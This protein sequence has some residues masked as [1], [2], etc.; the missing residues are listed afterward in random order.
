MRIAIVAPSPNP[1]VFGGAENLLWGLL[2]HL[3]DHTDHVPELIKLPVRETSLVDLV[4]G[5]EAFSRLDLATFDAVITTKYPAW[6]IAHANH[7]VY[8]LHRCRG[9]YDWYPA[10]ELG[11]TEYAGRDPAAR[12]LLE[13][14]ARRR[15]QRAALPEFFERFRQLAA[16]SSAA[17]LAPHPSPLGRA[18]IRFLDGIG[19]AATSVRRYAAIAD[20]VRRRPDYFPRGAKVEVAFPPT[21]KTGFHDAGEEYFLTA[22]RFY[23]SKR[24]DLLIDAYR[25]TAIPLAFKI[26][27]TGGEEARLR[28]RAAGDSRIEFPGFV[29]DAELVELYSRAM[30]VPFAPQDEDFGYIALEAMLAGKPVITT[31]DSGGPMELVRDGVT[32]VVAA[33]DAACLARAFEQVYVER[34]WARGLGRNG[35]EV[36]QAVGWPRVMEALL[37]AVSQ[38][39]AAPRPPRPRVTVL[40]AYAVHPTDNGGRYRLHWLYKTLARHVDVDIVSLGLRTEGSDVIHPAEG[41]RELRVARTA[42]HEAADDAAKTESNAP[43]Y[44]ITALQNIHLTPD[45]ITVLRNSLA[46]SRLA[47]LAHPYMATALARAGYEGAFIHESQNCE[48]ALKTRMLPRNEVSDRLL[49]QVEMAEA[50]CVRDAR[51]VY[52]CCEADAEGLLRQYGGR[53]A[54]MIVVPN[55]TDT[56]A[57]AYADAVERIRV[58]RRVG[59]AQQ[60]VALFL[61]SGHRPNL[62]AAEHLFRLAARMPDVAFAFVGNAAYAYTG[63]TFPEN[64]WMIGTVSEEVRNVWLQV[65]GVA[66]NPMLYGGGTNLKLLDYFAAGTPVVSTEIGIRGSGAEPGR[67][68]LVAGVDALEAPIRQALAGGPDIERMTREA[69]ALV[70]ENFDWWKL[71]DRLHEAIRERGLL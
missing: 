31:H 44:D 24:I 63:R 53:P 34:D 70:V 39:A 61:A 14:M 49:E 48:H 25:R 66:L 47:V 20:A 37:P 29:S 15:L 69:R 51:L 12:A 30:A 64:I 57:I 65:A 6:M 41:L 16:G 10:A 13:F 26:A 56:T 58:R 23:P 52:A 1:F 5:Y 2:E 18:V 35:R 28:E 62:E 21:R 45:Y 43:V 42:E 4:A 32:G 54:D 11:G 59:L 55:G 60:P 3:R 22:S 36:A 17:E 7:S 40:N 27:G 46:G 71:G 67:H 8:M 50:H 38:A 9:F 19:L 68:V 33:P